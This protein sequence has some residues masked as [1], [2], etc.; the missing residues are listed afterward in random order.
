[1]RLRRMMIVRYFKLL[2]KPVYRFDCCQSCVYRGNYAC[3]RYDNEGTPHRCN[4]NMYSE[5]KE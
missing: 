4:G 3:W 5:Y 2:S 1:M